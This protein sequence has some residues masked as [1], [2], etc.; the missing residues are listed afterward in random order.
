MNNLQTTNT[1]NLNIWENEATIEEIRKIYA[2]TATATEFKIFVELG[3]AANLNPFKKEIW[4]IKFKDNPAQII[5]AR[6]GYK[7]IAQLNPEYE[8]HQPCAIYAND[9]ITMINGEIHH[10]RANGNRGELTGAYCL[11][12]RKSSARAMH[13][14]VS[15]DEYDSGQGLWVQNSKTPWLKAKPETMIKKVAEA[16]ALRMAFQDSFA[17]TYIPEEIEEKREPVATKSELLMNKIKA[18]KGKVIDQEPIDIT[19]TGVLANEEE[20]KEIHALLA[21]K[22]FSKKRLDDAMAHYD[23][24]KL[25]DLTS[26][27][28]QAFI[29]I[30]SKLNDKEE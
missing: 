28:A 26:F 12:K 22:E 30:L 18:A 15:M 3:K 19:E 25:A 21:V 24:E 9:K 17:G 6:D 1:V 20:L 16:H 8:W 14:E 13:A 2:P 11:V 5:I 23:V 10:E 29:Q 4:C 27:Q 7:K